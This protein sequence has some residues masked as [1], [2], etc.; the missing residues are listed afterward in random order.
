MRFWSGKSGRERARQRRREKREGEDRRVKYWED[1][2]GSS[3]LFPGCMQ[4]SSE[5]LWSHYPPFS[6]TIC[7]GFSLSLSYFFVIWHTGFLDFDFFLLFLSSLCRHDEGKKKKGKR[8][9]WQRSISPARG[10]CCLGLVHH[11]RQSHL[12]IRRET[13]KE[14]KW[15]RK[16]GSDWER[17]DR[18]WEKKG[19]TDNT[20]KCMHKHTHTPSTYTYLCLD[21]KTKEFHFFSWLKQTHL[22]TCV[23]LS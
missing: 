19:G 16:R 13:L 10:P 15:E 21:M 9:C 3:N 22:L 5:V 2:R 8:S 1:L 4:G 7:A 6:L 18:R 11:G 14:C 23:C 17:K 20:V 12:Q